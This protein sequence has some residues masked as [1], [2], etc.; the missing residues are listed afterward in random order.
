MDY[1]T[2]AVMAVP[3]H[4]ERDRSF[5]QKYDLPIVQS[6]AP[7]FHVDKGDDAVRVDKELERRFNMHVILKNP[8]NDTYC[9]LDREK[10]GRK[11]MVTGGIEKGENIKDAAQRKILEETGYS[12]IQFVKKIGR[13]Q[14]G[15]SRAPHK[16]VNRYSVHYGLVFELIDETQQEVAPQER[17]RHTTK[18]FKKDEIENFLNCA[19]ELYLRRHYIR[20]LH[21]HTEKG[22]VINSGDYSYMKSDEAIEQ[23]QNWLQATN[24]GKKQTNYRMQ[25]RCFSRQR[26]RGEPFPMIH[27]PDGSIITM[28]SKELPLT[29]PDVTHYEPT[30]TAEGPLAAI[31]EWINVTLPDGTQAKRESNTMPGWAGS[32]WYWLRYMDPHNDKEIFDH[33]KER[34]RGQ[35][36]CYIGGMEHAARHLIYARYWHKFLYDIK[37][38]TT[39]EPFKRLE[40]V[41]IVLAEDGRKMSKRRGNVINPDHVIEEFGSDTFRCYEMFMAP[42]GQ[43]VARSTNAVK[44]VKRFL[45]KFIKLGEKTNSNYQDS[46]EILSLVHQTIKKVTEDIDTFKFNT[47]ISQLMIVTNALT[48]EETISENILKDLVMIIAPF[49]PHLAEEMREQLGGSSMVFADG[50]WPTYDPELIIA[51]S[52]TLPIQINGKVR[53]KIEVSPEATQEEV[54]TIARK[55]EKIASY[56]PDP[57]KKIVYVPGRIMNMVG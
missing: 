32:S 13:E 15:A 30:G 14:H 40:T 46:S 2:G 36:D 37:R 39:K 48:K 47:A 29:L 35:V 51:D 27:H 3:A 44:G 25:D 38:V 55:D 10:Y 22:V 6:I 45:D 9:C 12:N 7:Y 8:K 52:V 57:I 56:I 23:M 50:K 11:T 49:A 43:E 54:L 33:K 34:Y 31:D 1:G 18:W 17:A 20:D 19:N 21:A 16:E 41:G 53:G 28:D 4:D 24:R 5:A 42:F 26:Y